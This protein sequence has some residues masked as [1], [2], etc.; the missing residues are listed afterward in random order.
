MQRFNDY[1]LFREMA[2]T[3]D[4]SKAR[5]ELDEFDKQFIQQ[6]TQQGMTPGAAII[7]RYT[8]LLKDIKNDG[9]VTMRIGKQGGGN[10][11]EIKQTYYTQLVE[12]L[13]KLGLDD[14]IENGFTI[15]NR[16]D[17]KNFLDRGFLNV[18][19][20]K[21]SVKE[22]D[23]FAK[24]KSNWGVEA[25]LQ[26]AKKSGE[27]AEGF[28]DVY[29]D[30]KTLVPE[31]ITPEVYEAFMKNVREGKYEQTM[32][33]AAGKV[34]GVLTPD[35]MH[36]PMQ[37]KEILR[38]VL[39][40][41]LIKGREMQKDKPDEMTINSPSW[42]NSSVQAW[43][44]TVMRQWHKKELGAGEVRGSGEGAGSG[45]VTAYTPDD[46]ASDKE[47]IES[48][49]REMPRPTRIITKQAA[50]KTPAN[51][52]AAPQ[53]TRVQDLMLKMTQGGGAITP[54][55]DALRK[56]LVSMAPTLGLS[57][58]IVDILNGP[59]KII[60]PKK[61]AVV[62]DEDDYEKWIQQQAAAYEKSIKKEVA[63]ATSVVGK[64]E[65][66]PDWQPEGDPTGE[67][68][69]RNDLTVST[70]KMKKPS[71]KDYAKKREKY[72]GWLS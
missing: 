3:N 71:F 1:I 47:D 25:S 43:T 27:V 59:V 13:K 48:G 60:E 5:L 7:A 18:N 32:K 65:F 10:T 52:P 72:Q 29:E 31:Y 21:S 62:D 20:Q 49:E 16:P 4:D 64:P 36:D 24:E 63:G 17:A 66:G 15:F 67:V 54:E 14:A 61:A 22:S 50:R 55:D 38:Q 42:F 30:L 2:A 6:A 9:P 51:A 37:F 57:R 68:A 12:K 11:I 26:S 19:A 40:R 46:E 8:T 58:D 33:A 28:D 45:A 39:A 44:K 56:Q 23:K 53:D 34:I 69:K 70:G 41:V 35:I